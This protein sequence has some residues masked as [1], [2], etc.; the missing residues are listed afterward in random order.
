MKEGAPAAGAEAAQAHP[1]PRRSVAGPESVAPRSSPLLDRLSRAEPLVTVELRPPRAGLSSE[2]SMDAWI[3]MHHA[4]RRLAA[5]ERFV[6]VTDNAVGTE[7]EENLAHLI[8]NLGEG[9]HPAHVVP[10]LTLKHTLEYCLV[11]AER[12]SAAGFPALAVLGGDHRVG[13]P[14]CLP[15]AHMLRARIRGRV[16]SLAL[17]G[18]ANPHRHPEEQAGFLAHPDAHADFFLTQVVSH[19]SAARVEAFVRALEERGVRA[20]GVFG[21]FFYRSA[22]PATLERLSEFFPVPAEALAREFGS[23]AD[24]EEVCA[25]SI[26]ALRD[27]GATRVY[28]S[29]L[30]LTRPDARLRRILERV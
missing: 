28:V 24:A 16:P 20:P 9:A 3:D 1:A 19:H 5:E 27:A 23:G 2:D 11:Y 10:F 21:V 15:H 17:G 6:F 8:A 22:T 14:R 25:R 29:N 7:E 12:A 4:V 30:G 13:A 26:R 18:W